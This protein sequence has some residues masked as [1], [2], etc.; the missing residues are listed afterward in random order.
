[1]KVVRS[2]PEWK[3]LR[4]ALPHS[5]G[6]V[7]TMG[8][9]HEGHLSLV[10]R[11]RA[12]NEAVG[13]WIF[14]NP[15]QFMAGEDFATHPRDEARDLARLGAEGVDY[16]LAPGVE[17][18]YPD[19]FQTYV[20]VEA[21]SAPLEGVSRPGHFRGVAT[22]VAKMFCLTQPRAAYFGQKDAQQ[23]AVVRRMA[24]DLGMLLEGVVCPTIREPDGLAMSS[25]NAYLQPPERKAAAVLYRALQAAG[26][27][28]RQGERR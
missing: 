24:A 13:V 16:V 23:C 3:A 11:A 7:P 18:V 15:K 2:V 1:M 20:S 21:L 8:Y 17:G 12:E 27:A 22:V 4:P 26:R 10:R 5:L 19:G 6:L 9:L 28:F 14:V 25:R